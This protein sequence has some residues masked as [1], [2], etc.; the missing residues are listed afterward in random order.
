MLAVFGGL[1]LL[2]ASLG[3]YAVVAFV[4]SRRSAEM[5]I[6]I[7]LGA[8]GG[9]VFGMIVREMM[10]IVGIGVAMGLG[11]AWLAMP[12]LESLL[13]NI[14]PSDPLTFAIVA[15]LLGGVA[16]FATWLPARRA[17]RVDPMCALR[18]E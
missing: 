13:F 5:G 9:S 4:V 1:A 3:L 12:V 16:L 14:A 18:F 6:R 8:S 17:A 7:A 11:L 2:L 15:A 10:T